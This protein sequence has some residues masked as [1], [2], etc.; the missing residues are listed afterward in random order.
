MPKASP[1][2]QLDAQDQDLLPSAMPEVEGLPERARQV[3]RLKYIAPLPLCHQ[4]TKSGA[5]LL[6]PPAACPETTQLA[7]SPTGPPPQ[8][9]PP[10]PCSSSPTKD[11]LNPTPTQPNPTQPN[12][13]Q[14]NPTQPNPT[15]LNPT[16]LNPTQL[17]PTQPNPHPTQLNPTQH[18]CSRFLYRLR[19]DDDH[20]PLAL[21]R[22]NLRRYHHRLTR[23]KTH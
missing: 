19:P 7:P 2:P 18:A 13:T 3:L 21:R 9:T 22:Q 11:I 10:K 16:Q 12:P 5:W 15:Q 6:R 1:Y 23:R 8:A 14:P 17:N 20:Y 4:A